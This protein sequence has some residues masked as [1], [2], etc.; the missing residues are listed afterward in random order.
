MLTQPDDIQEHALGYLMDRANPQ[1]YF[2]HYLVSPSAADAEDYQRLLPHQW[3]RTLFVV[4]CS[5]QYAPITLLSDRAMM[6]GIRSF[7]W[8]AHAYLIDED[9]D[10][11][12]ALAAG[13]ASD[14]GADYASQVAT[15]FQV[16]RP[17]LLA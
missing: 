9:R 6:A 17:R 14:R 3:I 15:L 10:T 8:H 4:N 12:E 13:A 16:I 5:D 2:Y 1:L 7:W 11:I